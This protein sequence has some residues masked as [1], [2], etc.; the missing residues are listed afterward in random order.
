MQ[1]IDLPPELRHRAQHFELALKE[2]LV[3]QRELEMLLDVGQPSQADGETVDVAAKD[4]PS[5][6]AAGAPGKRCGIRRRFTVIAGSVMHRQRNCV[7]AAVERPS[8]F[9]SARPDPRWLFRGPAYRLG[10]PQAG[11]ELS[12]EILLL[13][14]RVFFK[15]RKEGVVRS[16]RGSADFAREL[17]GEPLAD[18][19][20]IAQVFRNGPHEGD[21][22]AAEL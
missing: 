20:P 6:P 17:L 3:H 15:R 18:V 14:R 21:A 22:P 10:I 11:T 19:A 5:G 16:G 1:E 4:A 7:L 13:A 2:L 9:A 12:G 8:V